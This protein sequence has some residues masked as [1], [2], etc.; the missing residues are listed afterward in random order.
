MS[1]TCCL[2]G[3]M[4]YFIISLFVYYLCDHYVMSF[5]ELLIVWSEGLQPFGSWSKMRWQDCVAVRTRAA[6][7]VDVPKTDWLMT[8][9][10]L[11][12]YALSVHF[13]TERSPWKH[14]ILILVGYALGFHSFPNTVIINHPNQEMWWTFLWT[15]SNNCSGHF[16]AFRGIIVENTTSGHPSRT[17]HHGTQGEPA[18][19]STVSAPWL[20]L[21]A[22]ER[23]RALRAPF[24]CPESCESRADEARFA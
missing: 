12:A 20:F 16:E 24:L 1:W 19:F 4:Y 23:L 10:T 22:L 6:Q 15:K 17:G 18:N 14:T 21:T 2:N 8:N 11:A 5:M 13:M 3:V 9:R 7:Q